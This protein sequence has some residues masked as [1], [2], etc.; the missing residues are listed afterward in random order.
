MQK[1]IEFVAK[2]SETALSEAVEKLHISS[3]KIYI[4]VLGEIA[5]GTN[6]EALVDVNLPLEG[7]RYLEGILQALEVEYQIESRTKGGEEEIY[8]VINSNENPLLIGS[9][10]KTLDAFLT[11][12]KTLVHNY[13][14]EHIVMSLDIGNY[15]SN[16][17]RQ[18]EILAT[19]TA[20]SVARSKVSC[21]L[22]P[23]NSYERRIIHEKLSEW[24]DV[25]TES[26]GEGK[27][28]ALVIKPVLK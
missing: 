10:G 17:V 25:Y 21:K 9:K 1:K 14:K 28:R 3:D 2:N 8:Y 22:D 26:E 5:E 7:K 4:N 19:K 13:T 20:K 11:L 16:R 12:V 27:E 24:H 6:V 15:R 23:M 18:L